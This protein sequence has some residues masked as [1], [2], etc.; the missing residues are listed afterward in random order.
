MWITPDRRGRK[1]LKSFFIFYELHKNH[2]GEEGVTFEMTFF[3]SIASPC[4]SQVYCSE[5]MSSASL[6]VR[7]HWNRPA[8][9][10]LYRR[11]NPSSS[12]SRP[13]ILS[14]R[15]PQNRKRMPGVNGSSWKCSFTIPA[16]PS[17][18]KRKSV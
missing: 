8:S 11:R 15:R 7:G 18:P 3:C 12:H 9:R 4:I 5:V 1:L 2:K 14:E 17:M 10:R 16:S 13:L 6:L